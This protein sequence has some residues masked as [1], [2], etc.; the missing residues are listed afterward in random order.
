MSTREELHAACDAFFRSRN[1]PASLSPL[2]IDQRP[3]EFT[4][5]KESP[6]H[7]IDMKAN[8]QI[9]HESRAP[10]GPKVWKR[11]VVTTPP[12]SLKTNYPEAVKEGIR[13]GIICKPKQP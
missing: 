11:R 13:Q 2:G 5:A 8:R 12:P 1:M 7:E 9:S 4:T 3:A 6:T 10:A